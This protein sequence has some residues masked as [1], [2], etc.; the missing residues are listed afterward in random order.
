[1]KRILLA[2]GVAVLAGGGLWMALRRAPTGTLLDEPASPFKVET[3]P[4]GW[5]V[6]FADGR[7]ALRALRWLTPHQPGLLV[8]QV[9]TQSDRQQV[10][11]F[12]EG[13]AP[14]DLMVPRPQGVGE[15][16]WRFA[17]LEDARVLPDGSVLLLYLP[18]QAGDPSLAV[19][20]EPGA[21]EARWSVR[22]TFTR[23]DLGG[24]AEGAV[25]LYGQ[26]GPVLRVPVPGAGKRPAP[27]EIELPPEAPS[28]DALLATGPSSFLAAT[29]SGLSAW[30]A[31]KGWSHVAGPAER[32]LP[33]AEWRGSVVQ[34]GRRFWWQAVPGRVAEVA[35]DG[36]VI[37]DVEPG[38]LPAEDPFAR[39]GR[40]LRLAGGDDKG[41]LW[42]APAKP[43][44]PADA[45]PG[46]EWA[47]WLA[48]G[49][50]RVYR[51]D[52]AREGL[53][54]LAWGQAWSLVR[55]PQDIPPGAPRLDPASGSLLLEGPPGAVWWAPLTAL[56][57]APVQAR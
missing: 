17:R 6:A 50:D 29:P 25:F 13:A 48:A 39:D 4:P 43:A 55:P 41:R 38:P 53:E 30:S 35:R 15:G 9:Q 10:T 46:G 57:F 34:A 21:G 8:A 19:C 20:A 18:G 28:V 1:M 14:A 44:V 47:A 11:V 7:L 51:W 27:R 5:R 54:R 42:F 31:A 40:L 12:R 32:G 45:D 36:S 33:C 52:P 49:L 26:A 3:A 16:Y 23:M 37:E 2:A 24:G 56:P 22:G